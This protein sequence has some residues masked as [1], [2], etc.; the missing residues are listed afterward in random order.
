MIE[1]YLSWLSV[2]LGLGFI[3]CIFAYGIDVIIN[4]YK[5]AFDYGT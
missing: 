5:R 4:T 3:S 2:G 1:N